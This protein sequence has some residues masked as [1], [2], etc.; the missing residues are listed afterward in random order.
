MAKVNARTIKSF[1]ANGYTY[2]EGFDLHLS[3]TT[4][5]EWFRNEWIE[6]VAEKPKRKRNA[7]GHFLPIVR[8][9]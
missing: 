4:L 6:L 2:P 5:D 3:R 8:T 7:K 1:W 9:G